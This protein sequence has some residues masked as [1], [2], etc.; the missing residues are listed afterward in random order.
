MVAQHYRWDFIGLS[1]DTKPDST[2]PKVANGSTYY[3][4]DTSKLYVWYN[5]QWYEKT[6]T[7][8]GGYELPIA[9]ASTLGGVKVGEGLEISE[10]GVLS[11]TGGGGGVTALTE[12]DYDYP[13]ENPQYLNLENL[14]VGIYYTDV[15]YQGLNYYMAGTT[16]SLNTPC[17]FIKCAGNIIC[18]LSDNNFKNK[19]SHITENGES[20]S[21]NRDDIVDNLTTDTGVRPLSAR[22][23][24]VL[25]DKIEAL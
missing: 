6:A 18:I 15:G 9:S 3:E 11:A 10:A 8:G 24:K 12:A 22:Q 17:T 25:N 19:I 13:E 2:N 7:G 20:V 14:P 16:S 23:G 5:N 4:S 21:L 1:T